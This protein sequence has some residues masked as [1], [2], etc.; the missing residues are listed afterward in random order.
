MNRRSWEI[1]EL[2]TRRYW[3]CEMKMKETFQIYEY[4]IKSIRV[5]GEVKVL[6]PNKLGDLT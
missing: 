4:Y 1:W 6:S 2:E 3:N 5:H